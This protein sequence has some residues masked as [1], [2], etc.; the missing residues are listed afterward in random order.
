MVKNICCIGAGYVGGPSMA[1]MAD[2]CPG[3]D[4][5]VV[6]TDQK[7]ID[8]WNNLN[9]AP[10][11]VYKR[12]L[13]IVLER[14]RSRNLH[15][16]T[17]VMGAVSKADMVFLAVNTPTEHRGHGAG[18]ASDLTYIE[19]ASGQITQSASR[20]SIQMERLTLPVRTAA[21]LGK[22]FRHSKNSSLEIL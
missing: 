22:I 18:A 16:S 19:K 21:G 4:I 12:G 3:V 7:R 1:V 20:S 14:V 11:P 9:D 17:D 6:D 5:H 15:F 2:N 10:L 13:Q 8:S